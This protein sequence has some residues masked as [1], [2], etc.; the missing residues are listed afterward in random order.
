MKVLLAICLV[1]DLAQS[2]PL[3]TPVQKKVKQKETKPPN[4]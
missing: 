2:A 3:N 1:E 4:V